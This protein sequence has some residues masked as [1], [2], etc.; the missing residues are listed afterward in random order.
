MQDKQDGEQEL[1]DPYFPPNI[2]RVV[3]SR[4][5]SWAGHVARMVDR[6]VAYRV[7]VAIPE[8]K[9]P[10]IRPSRRWEEVGLGNMD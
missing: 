6:R 2:I 10:I 8:R 5:V 1:Y 9:R 3:K 7:L 4:I